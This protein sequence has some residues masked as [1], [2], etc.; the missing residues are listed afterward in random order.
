MRIGRTRFE[1]PW[2]QVM[3]LLLFV[4]FTIWYFQDAYRAS[5]NIQNLLLI[6]PASTLILALALPMLVLKARQ[7]RLVRE[8]TARIEAD[9]RAFRERFGPYAAMVA[10]VAYT[11]AMPYLGFDVATF[12]FIAVGM[13]IH[14]ERR[15]LVLIVF[16]AIV[17]A[18]VIYA[19]KNIL[20]TPVPTLL[21]G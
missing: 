8:E 20:F 2:G 9:I 17:T 12:V 16:P 18:G 4:S 3:M 5:S 13:A 7:L 19:L 6:G 1:G 21:M 11:L 15:L 14:G 10:L